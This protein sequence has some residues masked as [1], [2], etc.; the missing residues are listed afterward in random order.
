MIAGRLTSLRAT[1]TICLLLLTVSS[2]ARGLDVELFNNTGTN[3]TVT[4]YD[5]VGTPTSET[6]PSLASVRITGSEFVVQGEAAVWKYTL[7]GHSPPDH[8][9]DKNHFNKLVN[10]QIERNGDIYILP[11]EA[12][13][14]PSSLLPQP[15]GYPIH[16]ESH[17][18]N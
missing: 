6:L 11:P 14:R 3:L 8:F 10:L 5:T 9:I 13:S 12:V 4:S 18:A 16:P 15:T 1:L 17:G 2:C 7:I